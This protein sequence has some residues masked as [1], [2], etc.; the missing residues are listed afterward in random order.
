[1]SALAINQYRL[2]SAILGVMKAAKLF[3]RYGN[4]LL[5]MAGEKK[6]AG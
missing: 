3:N 2:I 4:I 1:M 5:L 6:A